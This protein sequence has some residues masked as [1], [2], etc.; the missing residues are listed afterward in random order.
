MIT[1]HVEGADKLKKNLA[2]VS[3]SLRTK[4]AV[5]AVTEGAYQIMN[6]ARINAPHLT[7]TL[8][9][10]AKVS[11]KAA[12]S[13]AEAEISFNTVYA[14]IQ[15]YGGMTGRGRRVHIT[16]K[17]YLGRAIDMTRHDVSRVMAATIADY[18]GK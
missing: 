8:R 11:A 4:A 9:R 17:E 1:V 10:S 5:D 3:E 15:E 13:G 12:G 14:R 16:G 18:L 6:R 2:K 7:G